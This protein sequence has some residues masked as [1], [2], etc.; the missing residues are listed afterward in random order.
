MQIQK[1]KIM[2]FL[3]KKAEGQYETKDKQVQEIRDSCKKIMEQIDNLKKEIVKIPEMLIDLNILEKEYV[4]EKI[5][6]NYLQEEL[7]CPTNVHIWRKLE[8]TDKKS[9]DLI[10]KLQTL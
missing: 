8:S 6:T 7:K 10:I 9:Y 3:L 4:N 2:N 5:K 1:I